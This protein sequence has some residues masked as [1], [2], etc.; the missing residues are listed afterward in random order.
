M[1]EIKTIAGKVLYTADSA[2]DV[3][4]ALVEAVKADAYLRGADLGGAYLGGAYLRG[5]YLRGAY[6]RGADLRGAYLGGAY[7]GGAYLRG[8]YLRGAYLGGADL[9]GAY[10]G[11]AYLRGADLGG[12]DLRGADL[13]GADLGGA[14]LGGAYLRGADLRG[15][16]AARLRILPDEGDVIGW[17]K[18][19]GNVIVKLRIPGDA[20][21][22]NATGRKCRADRAEVLEIVGCDGKTVEVAASQHDEEFTYRAGGTVTVD[23]FDENRWN[24]CAPGI[25]FYITRAEAEAHL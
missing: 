13:R 1:I 23:D 14:D 4:T 11:G 5:A 12:A 18:C 10:L 8:A 24:E 9:R 20:R 15:A 3:R 17:K 16:N 19:R 25:H 22:S 2:S 21:R 7:L 6:L